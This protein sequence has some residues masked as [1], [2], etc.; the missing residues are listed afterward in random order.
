MRR[1]SVLVTIAFLAGLAIGFFARSAGI[2]TLLRRNTHPADLA[3]IEKLHQED[4]EATLKQDPI[5]LD[6]L[7][8]NDCIKV[9]VPG[10]PVVGLKGMK[11]MYAKFK[12]DYPEFR[13]LKYTND[14]TDVQIVHGWA[15]EVGYSE[16]TYQMSAKDK[17]IIVPRT[18]GMR[19][20]KRQSDGSWKFAVVG[21][22]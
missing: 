11:Q 8:S 13:V 18:E 15:I 1:I 7:W 5:Y 12:T 21:L 10:G 16:A 2:G 4:I 3:A 19:V 9:D 22:K 6:Q 20:L 14:V 17:P